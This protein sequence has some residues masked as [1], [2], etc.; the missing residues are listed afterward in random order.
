M[1]SLLC[2]LELVEWVDDGLDRVACDSSG[3]LYVKVVKRL[4]WKIEESSS[5]LESS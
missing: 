2:W 1:G 5:T 4:R 3:F